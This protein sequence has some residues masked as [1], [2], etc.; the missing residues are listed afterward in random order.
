MQNDDLD[1]NISSNSASIFLIVHRTIQENFRFFT[2]FTRVYFFCDKS[3]IP[4]FFARTKFGIFTSTP[5]NTSRKRFAEQGK[6]FIIKLSR[7]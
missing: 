2:P 6:L 3:P 7:R 4:F 1:Q 5:I